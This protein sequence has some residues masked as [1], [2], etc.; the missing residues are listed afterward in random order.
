MM[1]FHE[2]TL[3]LLCAS[4]AYL[5][6]AGTPQRPDDLSAH[7]CLNFSGIERGPIWDM[8]NASG[9]R[10]HVTAAGPYVADDAETLVEVAAAGLGIPLGAD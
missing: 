10:K 8:T 4:L 5:D 6:R 2:T 1:G 9:T 3:P 7:A